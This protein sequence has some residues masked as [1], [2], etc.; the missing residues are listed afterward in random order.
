MGKGDANI[1]I[2]YY[3]IQGAIN[4]VLS[5]S[6]TRETRTLAHPPTRGGRVSLVLEGLYID[7]AQ[8][9]CCEEHCSL[10]VIQYLFLLF[11]LNH[12]VKSREERRTSDPVGR[13]LRTGFDWTSNG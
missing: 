13:R 5:L 4:L 12:Q 6:L 9:S 1:L 10:V 3:E 11:K 7:C 8:S 2:I